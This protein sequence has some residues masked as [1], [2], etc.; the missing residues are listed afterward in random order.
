MTSGRELVDRLRGS[1]VELWSESGRLRYRSPK[2]VL[3]PSDLDELKVLKAEVLTALGAEVELPALAGDRNGPLPLSYAQQSLWFLG[4]LYP[5]HTGANE[6]FLIH[7]KGELDRGVLESAWN[8][9]LARHEI[10]RTTFGVEGGEPVQHINAPVAVSLPLE[11][12]HGE[13]ASERLDVLAGEEIRRSFDL[14]AGPLIRARLCRLDENAHVLLTTAHHI[15][16]DGLSV[17][18]IRDD[19]AA[20]YGGEQ[21]APLRIQYADFAAWQREQLS[22]ERLSREVAYWEAKLEDAPHN[23][24]LPSRRVEGDLGGGHEKRI[25]FQV[26][27]EVASGL[28]RL[29][30]EEGAT[31]FM[32]LMAAYR[33]LLSRYA[34]QHDVLIGSPVTYRDSASTRSLVGC[35]VNNVVFRTSLEG[36]PGFRELVRMERSTALGAYQHAGVPFEKVVEAVRPE[37][38]FGRHPLFQAM[39]LYQDAKTPAPER[40]GVCFIQDAL[41]PERDTYWDLELSVGDGGTKRSLSCFLGYRSDLYESWLAEGLVR[42][43]GQ[44]LREVVADADRP[45]SALPLVSSAERQELLTHCAGLRLPVSREGTLHGLFE[46][47]AAEMPE[48][49]AVSDAESCLS[50]GELNTR[51]NQLAH[52]LQSLGVGPNV[53]VGLCVQR[54]VELVVGM[55]GILK[56]GG[57]YVPLD[58][59]YPVERL[60]F[61]VDDAQARWVVSGQGLSPDTGDAQVVNLSGPHLLDQPTNNPDTTCNEDHIAYVIYTS[62]ST[63]QPKGTLIPHGNVIRLLRATEHWFGFGKDDV[64]TLF[65]SFA[66]DFSVWEVWGSL[67]YG[68]RLVVVSGDTTRSPQDF[69][70]LL[71]RERVTILNQT[72]SA[73][74]ELDRADG[75]STHEGALALRLVI[76]GGEALDPSMLTSWMERYGDERPVLVNMYGITETTVHVTYHVVTRDDARSA[77][78]NIGVPIP[79]LHIYL[80]DSHRQPVPAGVVGEMYI[81]GEGLAGGYLN[82]PSLTAERFVEHDFAGNGEPVRLYRTG[83]RARLLPDGSLEYLGRLDDQ[84]KLRGF[85]IELGEIETVLR[86]H[87]AVAQCVTVLRPHVSGDMQLVAYVRARDASSMSVIDLRDVA[88]RH[89]PEYMVPAAFVLVDKFPLTSNGKLDRS[90]LPE[91]DWSGE[92]ADD[93]VGPRSQTE[94]ALVEIWGGVLGVGRVGIHDSF[95]D[96]GGHSLLAARLIGQTQETLGIALPLRSLFESPTIA[97]L[98]SQVDTLIWATSQDSAIPEGEREEME[99]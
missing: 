86:A 32:V 98:A 67:A 72:P 29:A 24:S 1:G 22:G 15:I 82:R 5:G 56:A 23:V 38:Q 36:D 87:P 9:V 85:R 90:A 92:R 81:A 49:V 77:Q 78:S 75:R 63:G 83:D 43:Y 64:W 6:Q 61:I 21:L 59:D 37:R 20:F 18:I 17:Q 84:V 40:G 74:Y 48:A 46:A 45:V 99:I 44:L 12:L 41:T 60:R 31:L 51:A 62:G 96:L 8:Q 25:G 80:L 65:H 93:Y 68:G 73:F 2:G 7:L 33:V 47:R 14:S 66:F 16:A 89:L 19:L 27:A 39:F 69:L 28:K 71:S 13:D 54:S 4:E 50:Y 57:A 10:L 3:T 52:H 70:Q 97:A 95:F 35:M 55:L 76:F 34:D 91:P 30:R 94:Q 11:D 42:H 26:D 88:R 79:D 53:L 58:P